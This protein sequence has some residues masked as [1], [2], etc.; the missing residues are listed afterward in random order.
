MLDKGGGN[1]GLRIVG[2]VQVIDSIVATVGQL[3]ALQVNMNEV[4]YTEQKWE[5]LN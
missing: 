3:K 2:V 1:V 4:Y 5:K